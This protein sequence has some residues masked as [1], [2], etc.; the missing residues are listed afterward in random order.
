MVRIDHFAQTWL[1]ARNHHLTLVE[2]HRLCSAVIDCVPSR[3]HTADTKSANFY[4]ALIRPGIDRA[5]ARR[6]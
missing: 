3:V 1:P 5:I 4:S 2:F 6:N